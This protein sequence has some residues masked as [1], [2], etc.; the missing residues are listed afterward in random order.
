MKFDSIVVRGA[1]E[2]N[3]KNID[4]QIPRDKM[5]V[6]TG[7]SGSGKSSLAFDTLY[8]EGQRRYVESL[9]AYARQFLGQME[10]PKV[11]YIGG[12][13]P[14]I[15]IEQKALS[16]NPRSTVATV[17]E[18]YD[19][20]RVLFA[21]VGTPHCYQC[22]REVKPQ[23]AQQIIDQVTNL[24]P[25][26]RFQLLAPIAKGRKGTFD[27]IFEQARADGFVR[28][29]IDGVTTELDQRVKLAKTKKHDIELVID[30]LIIPPEPDEDFSTRLADSVET[31][32]RWG[33]GVLV[34]D[35]L[36]GEE[37]IMSEK[38]A[39][40]HCGLSFPELTPHMFSFNSPLGMCAEC[41]GLG[42]RYEFDPDLFVDPTKSINEGAVLP[43]GKIA[44]K[45]SWATQ[46]ANQIAERYQINLNTVW[47]EL[48]E[49]V[50]DLILNG[51]PKVKFI[52]Q[53]SS[54]T[55][56]W[57]HEGVI[58]STKRRYHDTQSPEM[59]EHYSRYLS[60]QPCLVCHGHR[61]RQ[62]ALAVTV[63]GL[64]ISEVISMNVAVVYRWI[65]DLMGS[66]IGGQESG[67]S[68]LPPAISQL[69]TPNPQPLTP[70]FQQIAHE[71][72]K[73]IR[74]RLKFM[75]DVGLHYLT[76]DRAAPSLSGGEGQR[77]RLASQIGSGLVGVMYILDEPSIGLHQ[78]DN[79][80]L[81]ESLL[82]LRDLGNTVLVVEHD[83]ETMEAA[84][85]IIDFGP[86]AGI[87]GGEVVFAGTP[88]EIKQAAH[89]LT[90]QYL[91]GQL[92]VTPPNWANGRRQTNGK[93]LT[94]GGVTHHNLHDVTARFPLGCFTCITGVSGSGKS[95][96]ITETLYPALA[97]ILHNSQERPGHY[98]KLDGLEAIDKV[99][100]ITQDPIGRTPRSNPATY[101]KVWDD[102][103]KLLAATNE[104]KIRGYEQ[105]RFSFNVKGG[106]CEACEGH[107]QKLVE[108]H[109]LPDVWV[110]CD[111]CNGSRFNRE[112][113][114]IRYKGK[115]IADILDLD[116][117]ES[118]AFFENI[119]RVRR[120]LNT[121]HDVGLDY[122]KL[123]Q[124]ATTLSGG[125][126]QRVKLAKELSRVSTG[127]TIYI[128]DEPTTGLHFVYI[129]KLLDVLHRLTDTGNTV[130]VIEHNLD[131]IRSADWVID[132][133]PEGG[134]AGGQIIAIGT[135][136][137]IAQAEQSYTGQ[138]LR[139][140]LGK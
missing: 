132:L 119:P 29:R 32:L 77:I 68:E 19:Y 39:C 3:L 112:T 91:S 23:T 60:Q 101:V 48:P 7:V 8:A 134:D 54:F 22:G 13:S 20:L 88:A 53:G 74:D 64:R 85:W 37:L 87:K 113:L 36:E 140:V 52:Y 58:K 40:P 108:M 131:V 138:F 116:V 83:A 42:V 71:L 61:L 62:E 122:I 78:R 6:F 102:I 104:A 99:I 72:L 33:E 41:N 21:R 111:V 76:L 109:F 47:T 26:T 4:V 84:D 38:N 95:S 14:A 127:D 133:G 97:R 16:K 103:R 115:N 121:L 96:L 123:G 31:A 117:T 94:V 55:G 93:W 43:W 105:G 136:E 80:R 46:I 130:V 5:V 17:T 24:A 100:H 86:G 63:G 45:D 106:R 137:D 11:D 75:I 89:S 44:K 129:Q 73:E 67:G 10:K 82:R 114:Q 57:A 128:L 18:V 124:S 28:A 120:V 118:L 59:R 15:A 34:V 1:K 135:P 12:L 30:R 49:S 65:M 51:D 126:A 98:E 27:D 107:G 35:V 90:G 9:S 92:A 50:R 110:L 2:H 139:R 70:I 56:N 25:D 69:S 66:R 79:H 125:E 81:L